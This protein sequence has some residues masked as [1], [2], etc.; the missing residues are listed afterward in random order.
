MSHLSPQKTQLRRHLKHTRPT[1]KTSW[2]KKNVFSN[3]NARRWYER[4]VADY[5]SRKCLSLFSWCLN[6]N[7]HWIFKLFWDTKSQIKKSLIL[8]F[9]THPIQKR[10][11]LCSPGC[12]ALNFVIIIFFDIRRMTWSVLLQAVVVS[13]RRITKKYYKN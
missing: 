2:L 6:I 7:L 12:P 4:S 1:V 5:F 8:D 3:R 11:F 9:V 10:Y 13:N